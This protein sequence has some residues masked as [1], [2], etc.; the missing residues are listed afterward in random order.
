MKYPVAVVQPK[1]ALNVFWCLTDFC[2]FRCNYCPPFLHCGD[3]HQ[4]RSPGFPTDKE[5]DKFL[6]DLVTK[7]ANGRKLIVQ[8][9]GGEP[10]LH[11]RLP[12]IIRKLK[13]HDAYVGM[14]T[15]GSKPEDFWRNILPLNGVTI[16]IHPEFTKIDR[17]NRI[18]RII[19]ES[20]TR[21]EFNLSCDPNN[22]EKMKEMYDQLD[23]DLKY[24]VNPKILE[25]L[26]ED[27]LKEKHKPLVRMNYEYEEQQK[28]WMSSIV[29]RKKQNSQKTAETSAN[30]FPSSKLVFSDGSTLP[31]IGNANLA[32]MNLNGWNQMKGWKCNV[33]SESINIYSNGEVWAGICKSKFLGHICTFELEK[34]HI[35]CQVPYCLSSS[36]LKVNKRK[37]GLS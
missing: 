18:S 11:P 8:L 25:Y 7:H 5:L 37:I 9:S 31:L 17:I 19:L 21:L 35:V 13:R 16:S 12:D 2:N 23:D 20:K 10:T 15:N 36:D 4:G 14:T 33:G 29:E 30:Q 27:S 24:K 22:W 3:H 34:D 1:P 26:T 32:K 6:D 28:E